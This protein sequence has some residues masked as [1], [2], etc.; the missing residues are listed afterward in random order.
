MPTG[1]LHRKRKI[2]Y[3]SLICEIER[4]KQMNQ[5]NRNR[6][7]GIENKLGG[8]RGKGLGE[9]VKKVEELKCYKIVMV[10]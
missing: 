2:P 7:I 8:A 3:D 6:L 4:T 9:C 5:Q 10:I 1:V